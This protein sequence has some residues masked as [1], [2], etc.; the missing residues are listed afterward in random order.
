[1]DF[2]ILRVE[3]GVKVATKDVTI[4]CLCDENK[5]ASASKSLFVEAL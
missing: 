1:V 4:L 2:S 3:I 5:V